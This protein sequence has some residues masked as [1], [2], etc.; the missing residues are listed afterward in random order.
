MSIFQSDYW[1]NRYR[2]GGTSGEGS[3]GR[4]REWKWKIIDNYVPNIQS[5]IDVGCGDL[6]FWSGREC[7]DYTGI[8]ISE[9]ILK[10]NKS[11]HPEWN[12]IHSSSD[13]F[14]E[15]LRKEN[16]FC[17]DI[18][19]HIINE[20]IFL[21][22]LTNLCQ[23]SSKYIFIHTWKNNPF[24]R[25][26]ALR[27]ILKKPDYKTTKYI[28]FPAKTDMNYQHFRLL[29]DYLNIFKKHGFELLAEHDNPNHEG[30]MYI[31]KM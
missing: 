30:C 7:V 16:V 1:E 6:S 27:R 2:T 28:F 10:R 4:G 14:I 19:F 25:L 31:L 13:E 20:K 22:T 18:L 8:D 11:L 23:Y 26:G 15:N 29:T 5:V 24:S 17:F 21:K 3:I 9:T 12:F